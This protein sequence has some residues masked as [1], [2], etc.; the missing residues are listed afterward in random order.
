MYHDVSWYILN[1]WAIIE[2]VEILCQSVPGIYF[3]DTNTTHKA[4]MY[5][6]QNKCSTYYV[7][8]LTILLYHSKY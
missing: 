4:T 8:S 3:I 1:N 6:A 7:F 5:H 2:D